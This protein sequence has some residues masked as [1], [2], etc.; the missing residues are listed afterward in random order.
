VLDVA[1][2]E[3]IVRPTDVPV[4]ST[5][6]APVLLAALTSEAGIVAVYILVGFHTLPMGWQKLIVLAKMT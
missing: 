5:L 1:D 6:L 2:I 3:I 4:L